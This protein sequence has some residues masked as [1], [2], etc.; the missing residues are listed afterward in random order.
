VLP[1]ALA[2]V[3]EGDRDLGLPATDAVCVLLVDGL[4]LDA[5]G[6]P[7]AAPL[8]KLGVVRDSIDAGF[9]ATTAVSLATLGTGS[10]PGRHG[11]VGYTVALPDRSGLHQHLRWSQPVEPESWQPLPTVLER[12]EAAGIAVTT[13]SK[14][15]F[16][17]SGLTRAALRGGVFRGADKPA[18]RVAAVVSALNRGPALVYDYISDLDYAGHGFGPGSPAWRSALAGVAA[19]VTEL[20]RRL[21]SGALLLVTGDH[22]MVGVSERDRVDLEAL[23]R[24]A[25]GVSLI[26][27]EP[28]ARHIYCAEERAEDVA[29]AW[30]EVLGE[31]AWVRTR[32]AAIAA[33]WFGPDVSPDAARR[34][35]EVVAAARGNYALCLPRAEPNETNLAGMHGSLTAVEQQVPLLLGN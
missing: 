33:G 1:A 31:R 10:P 6:E 19:E 2:A 34:I 17:G 20:V 23:P 11:I 13:V 9:P 18:D 15:Q 28:R 29:E 30:A 27:G 7:E 21:P 12:A 16:A 8:R 24:L 22:G 14:P 35:G 32:K 5:L 26:G 3:T 25:D 4:G